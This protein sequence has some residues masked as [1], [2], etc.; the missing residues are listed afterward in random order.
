[1]KKIVLTLATLIISVSAAA[2]EQ[3]KYSGGMKYTTLRPAQPSDSDKKAI[4]NRT[5]PKEEETAKNDTPEET[6]PEKTPEET[7]W[8]RYK[9][10]AAGK[11]GEEETQ[12][13]SALPKAPEVPQKPSA[14]Q[15]QAATEKPQQRTGMA[16]LIQEYQR[17]KERR[18][19]MRSISFPKPKA[20]EVDEPTAATEPK[21]EEN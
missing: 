19:Q 18:S 21:T 17:N 8:D 6:E 5:A 15:K 7:V 1:M 13:G 4:Y 12:E 2:A 9:D 16:G 11:E 20:P 10:L 3:P 14:P